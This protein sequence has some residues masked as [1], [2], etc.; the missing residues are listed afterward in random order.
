MVEQ[1]KKIKYKCGTPLPSHEF[2]K[3]VFGKNYGIL[4]QRGFLVGCHSENISTYYEHPYKGRTIQDEEKN[5]ILKNFG[6]DKAGILKLK[7]SL[8]KWLFRK[9]SYGIQKKLRY[10]FGEIIWQRFYNFMRG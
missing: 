2:L 10:I 8:R 5:N 3:D 6:L 4:K 7:L 9:L 1:N